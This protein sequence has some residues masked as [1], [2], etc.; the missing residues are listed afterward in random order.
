MS[1]YTSLAKLHDKSDKNLLD[2]IIDEEYHRLV[3]KFGRYPIKMPK[4]SWNNPRKS[5]PTKIIYRDA[6]VPSTWSDIDG[7]ISQLNQIK[8]HHGNLLLN[9]ET[10]YYGGSIRYSEPCTNP[11]YEIQKIKYDHSCKIWDDYDR[12]LAEWEVG[13]AEWIIRRAEWMGKQKDNQIKFWNIKIEHVKDKKRKTTKV[14]KEMKASGKLHIH[15]KVLVQEKGQAVHL[16]QIKLL[17][18]KY[19]DDSWILPI[20]KGYSY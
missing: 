3:H 11:N 5:E 4:K 15:L 19:A 14:A 12:V 8:A 7:L 16:R 6:K 18:E 10:S 2:R 20:P 17:L 9:L 13:K 1:S